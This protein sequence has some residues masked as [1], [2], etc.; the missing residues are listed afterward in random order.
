MKSKVEVVTP[1]LIKDLERI[2]KKYNLMLT[3]HQQAADHHAGTP[4][5][6]SGSSQPPPVKGCEPATK[7]RKGINYNKQKLN[8]EN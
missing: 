3:V 1:G 4:S 2:S 7:K 6:T 8:H 5:S